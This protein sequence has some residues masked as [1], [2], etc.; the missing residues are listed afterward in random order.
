MIDEVLV[1]NIKCVLYY[2]MVSKPL[3]YIKTN[4]LKVN[5][6]IK[7]NTRDTRNTSDTGDMSDK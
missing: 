6:Y 2:Y 5:N 3:E 4:K 7:K 1:H